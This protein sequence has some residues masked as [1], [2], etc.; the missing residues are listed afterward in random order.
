MSWE[1]NIVLEGM[2]EFGAPLNVW[3]MQLERDRYGDRQY[4]YVWAQL[5]DDPYIAS[6]VMQVWNS[7]GEWAYEGKGLKRFPRLIVMER[8]ISEW[9]E[10][11]FYGPWLHGVATNSSYRPGMYPYDNWKGLTLGIAFEKSKANQTSVNTLFHTQ[12]EGAIRYAN[13]SRDH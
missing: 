5:D 9:H 10:Y 3:R 12:T 2:F 4:F 1:S 8:P 13:D 7:H 6:R 11:V